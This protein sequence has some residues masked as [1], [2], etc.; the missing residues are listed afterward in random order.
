[1]ILVCRD[2]GREQEVDL[3]PTIIARLERGASLRCSCGGKGAQCLECNQPIPAA[4]WR[5]VPG[6]RLCVEHASDARNRRAEEPGGSREA[7]KR[8]RG[9]WR[10]GPGQ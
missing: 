2:C 4:R 9:G 7:W 5:A 8:D 6:T 3:T 1:M 10:R